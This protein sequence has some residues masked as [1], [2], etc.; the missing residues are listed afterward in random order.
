M[1]VRARRRAPTCCPA[2]PASTYRRRCGRPPPDADGWC[3]A[4]LTSDF[5][6]LV[7][8]RAVRRIA[9]LNPRLPRTRGSFRVH[10]SELDAS[11]EAELP[12]ASFED[13]GGGAV[14]ARIGS[15]VAA[16][17]R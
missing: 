5:M 2:G 1:F 14:E 15:H 4:G 16:L 12:L 6:P 7:W 17:V 3:S 13:P 8:S 10:V 11:V 9:H